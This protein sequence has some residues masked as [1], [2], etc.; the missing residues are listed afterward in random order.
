[1]CCIS[2]IA[3]PIFIWIWFNLIMPV[4][5]KVKAIF[6][7]GTDLKEADKNLDNSEENVKVNEQHSQP[8]LVSS[9][10]DKKNS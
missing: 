8:D 5:N 9:P 1:M 7:P 2:C 10:E 3:I 4:L 6:W